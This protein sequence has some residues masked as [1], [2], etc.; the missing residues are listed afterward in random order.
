L[1]RRNIFIKNNKIRMSKINEESRFLFSALSSQ[2]DIVLPKFGEQNNLDYVK[3]GDDNKFDAE[4]YR[5]YEKSGIHN[6][7]IESKVKMI[8]GDGIIQTLEEPYSEASQKFI[9]KCNPYESMDEVFNKLAN[10]YE[11]TGLGYLEIIWAKDKKSIAEIYHIDTNK[12]RWGKMNDKNRVDTFYYS[13]DWSN[14]RK[15]QYKPEPIKIFNDEYNKGE[16]RQILPII[17]YTPGLDYYAYPDYVASIKWINI[18]TEIANFHFNNLKNGMA[19]SVF[20]KFPVGDTTDEERRNIEG[21]IKDKYTGTNQAGKFILSFYDAEATNQPE[22]TIMDQTNADKQYEL[23]NKT[24]LQQILI[25][26]KVTNENLVGISTPGKL[27]GSN[28]MLESYDI[29]FNNVIKVEQ[30]KLI[31]PFQRI[32]LINGMNDIQILNNKPF[33]YTL[34]EN[35]LKEILSTDELR[36][37][38]GYSPIEIEEAVEDTADALE[39]IEEDTKELEKFAGVRVINKNNALSAIPKA[40]LDDSYMWKLGNP[41]DEACPACIALDGKTRSLREWMKISIPGIQD[42]TNFGNIS[43]SS[44]HGSGKYGTFC[45]SACL[46]SLKKVGGRR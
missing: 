16:N 12:I 4:L 25:G 27:G 36:D 29:Y 32:M 26:H 11:I 21:A 24:T 1:R 35:S 2:E 9:D 17:R 33:E 38:I 40:N 41:L 30:K 37:L 46:C 44:P 19:P 28:E 15:H 14:Y 3:Y 18:D 6:A 43:F 45:Q 10:D 23:L 39:P 8:T 22:V 34:S 5:L 20:F 42:G 31:N 7:I 13:K